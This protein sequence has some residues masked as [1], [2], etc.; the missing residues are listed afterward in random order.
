[1]WDLWS[2]QRY[3]QQYNGEVL[4]GLIINAHEHTFTH[5]SGDKVDKEWCWPII[6]AANSTVPYD[7]RVRR[8]LIYSLVVNK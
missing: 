5:T 8:Q 3:G 7:E 6:P 4:Q 2:P 1:M